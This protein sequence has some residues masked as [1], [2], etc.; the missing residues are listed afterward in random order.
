M[1]CFLSNTTLFLQVQSPR[2]QQRRHQQQQHQQHQHQQHQQQVSVIVLQRAITVFN[3]IIS[4]LSLCSIS[5]INISLSPTDDI[6]R[7]MMLL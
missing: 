4:I 2:Q 5:L 1:F 6:D 3:I 7:L